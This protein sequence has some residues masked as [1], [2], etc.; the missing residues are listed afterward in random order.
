[1]ITFAN[2]KSAKWRKNYIGGPFA[3]RRDGL[4]KKASPACADLS[5]HHVQIR[6]ERTDGPAVR[7]GRER[8]LLYPAAE[9][10]QRCGSGEDRCARR[11]RSR[12]VDLFGQAASF[13]SVF[14]IC[15]AGDH[16]VSASTIYGGTYNLF[17]V[18]L[19]KLGIDVTFVDQD[20]SE[21]EIARRSV[22]IPKR[23]SA[24]RYPIPA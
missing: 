13:Y 24:K 4:P 12:H 23:C 18:T 10:D 19:P 2:L 17:G 7:S 14:N 8:L 6:D 16:V 15:S 1:M 22:R 20:A 3:F 11:R 5:E 21:E 9:P